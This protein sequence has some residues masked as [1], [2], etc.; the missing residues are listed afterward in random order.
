MILGAKQDVQGEQKWQ[1]KQKDEQLR[2][3]QVFLEDFNGRRL[4]SGMSFPC[5]AYKIRISLNFL[6]SS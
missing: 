5:K 6:K 4:K 3:F 2:K 1:K